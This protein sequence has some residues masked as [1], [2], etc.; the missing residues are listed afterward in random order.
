M[1]CEQIATKIVDWI[2][3]QA[4]E[5]G[6]KALVVGVSGG[7]DSALVAALCQK[8]GL[9]T[10]GVIMPCHSS[11]SGIERAWEVSR[12]FTHNVHLVDL[13]TAF[14]SIHSQIPA[15][16]DQPLDQVR[17]CEGALRSCL[18]APTLD[19]VA[20]LY[21][22]II[23]GTGNRDE[24]E[25]TRYYQKRGDG[26]VDI[27]PI[28][29]LHKSEVYE[30]SRFLGVPESVLKATPSA[31]LWGPDAGQEDEKQLGIT[32]PEI[33]AAIR[34]AEADCYGDVTAEDLTRAVLATKDARMREV[35]IKLADME[36]A[37]RH[38]ANL[39]IPVCQISR[40]EKDGEEVK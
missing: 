26:S 16:G 8:T 39:G 28:A 23:V 4:N 19:F 17:A 10:V 33:E 2:K 30:L 14:K 6:A 36:N 34:L 25:V 11:P 15:V 29:K 27:S 1:K 20:K 24:D 12:K 5:A 32:Y 18:R 13:E 7:V 38:K 22:G 21:G 40:W 35:L 31:D 9:K 37:S 3:E